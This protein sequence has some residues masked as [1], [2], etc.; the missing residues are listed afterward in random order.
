[1][2]TGGLI[3]K[4]LKRLY[5]EEVISKETILFWKSEDKSKIGFTE[6]ADTKAA[7]VEA[8]GPLFNILERPFKKLRRNSNFN[9][10]S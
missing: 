6:V 3:L 5:Y 2:F 8:L 9:K 10:V 1:M 4:L 7:A